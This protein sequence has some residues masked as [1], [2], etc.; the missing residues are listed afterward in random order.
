[1]AYDGDDVYWV[2][3]TSPIFLDQSAFHDWCS[4]YHA[5]HL[6]FP[7]HFLVTIL[8]QVNLGAQGCQFKKKPLKIRT[9]DHWNSVYCATI[10]FIVKLSEFI[11]Q[12]KMEC[13]PLSHNS[14]VGPCLVQLLLE[15]C[16]GLRKVA[17]KCTKVLLLHTH[18]TESIIGWCLPFYLTHGCCAFFAG[19]NQQWTSERCR[20]SVRQQRQC[21]D[22]VVRS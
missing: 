7:K 4:H 2:Y 19:G 3:G 1:M 20:E 10:T 13:F 8:G 16:M 22:L 6:D 9:H 17:R 18:T 5:G 15:V 12:F 14:K 21:I 11:P